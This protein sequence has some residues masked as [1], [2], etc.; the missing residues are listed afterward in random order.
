[1]GI[2]S[3][4]PKFGSFTS[5]QTTYLRHA[6][7]SLTPKRIAAAEAG[8]RIAGDDF[9]Q[10]QSRLSNIS[11]DKAETFIASLRQHPFPAGSVLLVQELD[12]L[13]KHDEKNTDTYQL[14]E[15]ELRKRVLQGTF[16]LMPP[17]DLHASSA[18]PATHRDH[19]Q[20]VT[21]AIGSAEYYQPTD[22]MVAE[23]GMNMYSPLTQSAARFIGGMARRIEPGLNDMLAYFGFG[24]DPNSTPKKN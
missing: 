2:S 23:L 17:L 18:I 24:K 21:E 4:T 19:A 13:A 22:P 16:E 10:T 11:D 7:P 20:I 6:R 5:E 12:R 8:H 1:M 15:L 3:T 14:L 9:V